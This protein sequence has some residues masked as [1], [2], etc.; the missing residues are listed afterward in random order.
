VI[1]VDTSVWI[2]H[3]RAADARLT[4]L[5]ER[6]EVLCR[7]FVIGELAMRSLCQRGVVLAALSARL[8]ATVA[9]D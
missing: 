3:L 7:P 1:L 4:P 6:S 2:G 9:S 5:L 8:G